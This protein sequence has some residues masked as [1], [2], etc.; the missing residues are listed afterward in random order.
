VTPLIINLIA[1]SRGDRG[2]G[3]K[4]TQGQLSHTAQWTVAI[5]KP[6]KFL[7][8]LMKRQVKFK[9]RDATDAVPYSTSLAKGSHVTTGQGRVMHFMMRYSLNRGDADSCH[10]YDFLTG[11]G[12]TDSCPIDRGVDGNDNRGNFQQMGETFPHS[13]EE[14]PPHLTGEMPQMVP[15]DKRIHFKPDDKSPANPQS[16]SIEST[17]LTYGCHYLKID[18]DLSRRCKR[19]SHQSASIPRS[20]GWKG[21]F[22]LTKSMHAFVRHM[23]VT[24]SR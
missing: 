4:N 3:G 14:Q 10:P 22:G 24:V 5:P 9:R 17:P 20:H 16:S 19:R 2:N 13:M 6:T 7:D 11:R 23:I 15:K 12:E 18:Q 1:E 21:N 8:F